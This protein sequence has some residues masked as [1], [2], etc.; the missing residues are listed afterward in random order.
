MLV[1]A[2]RKSEQNIAILDPWTVV[3][4][5]T[6]LAFG[7]MDIPVRP[8]IGAALIYEAVE[9]LVERHELGQN[10]F[11]TNR[12]ESL[13]NAAADVAA[14]ALGYWLGSLWNRT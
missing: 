12:P 9:Q 4:V 6:G 7:L 2:R 11:E 8:A 3:H 13:A 10:L 14:F 1:L 5:G